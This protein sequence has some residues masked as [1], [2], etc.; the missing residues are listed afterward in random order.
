MIITLYDPHTPHGTIIAVQDV[1]QRLQR[2]AEGWRLAQ[3]LLERPVDSAASDQV[4][5]FGALTIIIKLNTETCVHSLATAIV[6]QCDGK[7]T[8]SH[9]NTKTPSLSLSDDDAKDLLQNLLRWLVLATMDQTA[10]LSTQKLCQALSTFYIHFPTLWPSCV[11]S[12]LLCLR[13]GQSVAPTGV[14]NSPSITDIVA[15]MDW[16]L[17]RVILNFANILVTDVS[18]TDMRIPKL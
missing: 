5:F 6:S 11:K 17:V 15:G 2:S 10:N 4:R 13:T 8:P 14:A 12:L 16:H 18:K 7:R 9:A 1:L 3:T